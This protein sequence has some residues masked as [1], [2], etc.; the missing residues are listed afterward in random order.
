MLES[1]SFCRFVVLSNRVNV[2]PQPLAS[3]IKSL[4]EA[5]AKIQDAAHNQIVKSQARQKAY[6]DRFEQNSAKFSVGDL[7]L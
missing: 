3:Y 5:S 6:Y 7:V 1:P 2:D 4:K